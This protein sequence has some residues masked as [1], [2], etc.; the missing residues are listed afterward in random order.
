M[1]ATSSI[2][3]F[4][5][6]KLREDETRLMTHL[7]RAGVA[8]IVLIST[9]AFVQAA[10]RSDSPGQ[11]L[12]GTVAWVNVAA[13][14]VTAFAFF[15][16]ILSDERDNGTLL[17]LK[18]AS[19]KDGSVL[20]GLI[21]PRLCFALALLAVQ[22]PFALLSV[23]LGGV[24]TEQVLGVYFALCLSTVLLCVLCT[25]M[26]TLTATAGG[27]VQLMIGYFCVMFVLAY[28]IT[29][30]LST[31]N[32]DV[33]TSAALAAFPGVEVGLWLDDP[34]RAFL[35]PF[36]WSVL[37]QS[38]LFGV[39]AWVVFPSA[40]LA[41]GETK[42]TLATRL[43][44]YAARK[45]KFA[46]K[47][48]DRGPH[49]WKDYHL[50]AGGHVGI[51]L[52][53]VAY[54]ALPT[55]VALFAYVA[56]AW[57]TSAGFGSS[58]LT[59]AFQT[60]GGWLLGCV[61]VG[62]TVECAWLAAKRIRIELDDGAWELLELLP[63]S[64]QYVLSG[65]GTGTIRGLAPGFLLGFLGLFVLG[66]SENAESAFTMMLIGGFFGSVMLCAVLVTV[67][68]TA[69]HASL[70]FK[71]GPAAGIAVLSLLAYPFLFS[72]PMSLLGLPGF[73]ISMLMIPAGLGLL[74]AAI[75][76]FSKRFYQRALRGS[77]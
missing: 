33:V 68:F 55:L 10:S 42:P 47:D 59:A 54:L 38:V 49:A 40:D 74:V 61:V 3:A 36:L 28:G 11:L 12:L 45:R 4:V 48:F 25:S 57:Q 51:V 39:I 8:G 5:T 71:A 31:A 20:A 69:S 32:D 66:A 34:N 24:T 43:R 64:R 70:R 9:I 30:G 77:D 7:L 67:W 14:M 13:V 65:K 76:T 26:A 21:V 75:T 19:E 17:L 22:I 6:R 53:C 23:T 37:I 73:L 56:T 44:V 72:M 46:P 60:F 16:P 52:R 50:V 35:G 2:S 18:L 1:N 27:V 41:S 58:A 62:L 63:T 15:T 29:L